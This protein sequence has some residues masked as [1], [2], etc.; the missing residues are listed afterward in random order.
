MNILNDLYEAEDKDKCKIA[1]L[2]MVH[3]SKRD[4]FLLDS[5]KAYNTVAV[6]KVEGA[7]PELVVYTF[8]HSFLSDVIALYRGFLVQF[9]AQEIKTV[10]CIQLL[11]CYYHS[12]GVLLSFLT[13]DLFPTY[14]HFYLPT[15]D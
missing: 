5:I 6:G 11:C 7:I 8:I 2:D 13:Q 4:L 3:P 9:R 15:G 14:I 12:A 10:S 1:I